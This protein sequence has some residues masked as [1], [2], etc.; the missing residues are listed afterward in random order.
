M[1]KDVV[2]KLGLGKIIL[3]W[4]MVCEFISITF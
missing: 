2:G 4:K 1:N 3:D